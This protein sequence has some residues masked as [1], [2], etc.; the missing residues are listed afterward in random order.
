MAPRHAYIHAHERI[1][2]VRGKASAQKCVH[3]SEQA[4]DWAYNHRAP[5]PL[6]IT[7]D[8]GLVYSNDPSF[9]LPMCR[10]CHRQFDV[11][12]A[13]PGCPKG[14]PYAGGN[15][16]ITKAGHR[17]CR[18]CKAEYQRELRKTPEFQAKEK[19]RGLARK[20]ARIPKP[21]RPEVTHCPQ[22][23]AYEGYNLII[24]NGKKKCRECGR[25]RSRRYYHAQKAKRSHP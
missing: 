1:R 16:Y 20:A 14:H 7:D 9:Y 23:H 18:A 24:D 13:K 2:K 17:S 11:T 10:K 12:H 19:L 15:L 25:D 22:G 6:E 8:A 3:C 5:D 4:S 21:K